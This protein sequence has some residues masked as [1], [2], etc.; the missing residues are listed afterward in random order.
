VLTVT[1]T[2]NTTAAGTLAGKFV[3]GTGSMTLAP[4]SA[5]GTGSTF[6]CT[7]SHICD[8]VSGSGTLTTGTSLTTGTL[9]TLT[10]PST[11]TNMANC[12]VDVLQTGVGR[13]TTT[14]WTESTTAVTLT[15]NT[16]LTASTAYTV[17]YWCGGN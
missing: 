7:G 13:V 8:S 12:I 6:V 16:A 5:A 10:F 2:G 15:A 9:G 4:G 1:N 17:K 14:T 11:R 3:T